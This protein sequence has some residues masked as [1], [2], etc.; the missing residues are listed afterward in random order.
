MTARR[1]ARVRAP[2]AHE[3]QLPV[4]GGAA[5]PRSPARRRWRTDAADGR[6]A[7]RRRSRRDGGVPAADLRRG[8]RSG[9]GGVLHA[10]RFGRGG[11]E[12][13]GGASAATAASPPHGERERRKGGSAGSFARRT[14]FFFEISLRSLAAVEL[15]PRVLFTASGGAFMQNRHGRVAWIV[16]WTTDGADRPGTVATVDAQ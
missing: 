3:R 16:G 4:C 5:T 2:D 7:R 9:G 12:R 11:P 1:D 8:G 10:L 13:R 15:G 14:L 6:R